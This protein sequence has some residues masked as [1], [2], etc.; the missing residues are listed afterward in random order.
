MSDTAAEKPW[1]YEERGT[2]QGAFSNEEMA[3]RI[4]SGQIPRGTSV[5]KKG[6]PGWLKVENT[7]LQQHLDD[8]PPP[9]RSAPP[10]A[11][12][13]AAI[14]DGVAGWSWGAFLLN[15]I[16]AIGNRTWIGLL[17]LVPLVGLVM[18]VVLG[19]KGREWAWKNR[20]WDSVEHFNA[21][22]KKWSFWG[23]MLV[24]GVLVLGI[25][26]GI[27]VPAYQ[28]HAARAQLA[29]SETT[30]AST[31]TFSGETDISELD[32]SAPLAPAAQYPA[33][34]ASPAPAVANPSF[35]CAKAST[36]IEHQIC[37]D[38]EL[39]DL[40][41]QLAETYRSLL[42]AL[43]DPAS[44]KAEQV[45][46]IKTQRNACT[47]TACLMTAYRSRLSEMEA[48]LQYLNKPADF[49]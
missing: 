48:I 17:T 38:P 3:E 24:L 25:L 40:D 6:F 42:S 15:W 32:S 27:V 8:A 16:W 33:E 36:A 44:T 19:F 14:P 5:W 28:Q 37:A 23:V 43:S 9:L 7:E 18:T 46:W 10:K 29:E 22:Q 45:N 12:G 20:E 11:S 2:R 21:V 39:A 31:A 26:G 1:Y 4:R 34:A 35:D 49:R 47:D 13:T 41:R 30:S